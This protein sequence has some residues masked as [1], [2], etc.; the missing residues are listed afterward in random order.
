MPVPQTFAWTVDGPFVRKACPDSMSAQ[1]EP[2]EREDRGECTYLIPSDPSS[3]S[4]RSP[5]AT[6][7]SQAVDL[8]GGQPAGAQIVEEP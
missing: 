3:S 7:I 8:T 5:R 6:Q 2:A 1:N 4:N